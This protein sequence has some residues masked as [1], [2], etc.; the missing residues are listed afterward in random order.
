MGVSISGIK[1]LPGRI[2]IFG[3]VGALTPI[4]GSLSFNNGLNQTVYMDSDADWTFE[5]E[6]FTIEWFQKM[7]DPV[8]APRPFSIGAYPSA[9]IAVSIEG[10]TFYFWRNGSFIASIPVADYLDT[11]VHFAISREAGTVRIYQNGVNISGDIAEVGSFS[12]IGAPLMIGGEDAGEG[13][14]VTGTQFNG[15]ITNFRWIKGT[16]VYTTDFAPIT[17]PLTLVTNTVFLLLAANEEQAFFDAD[18]NHF[19]NNFSSVVWSAET[20]FSE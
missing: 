4:G 5:T 16:A 20:P 10:D 18:D 11:W 7:T 17:T 1:S 6:D 2:H 8:S 14:V 15:F 3:G 9:Q 12:D 19:I 13:F